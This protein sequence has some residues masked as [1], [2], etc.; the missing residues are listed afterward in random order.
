LRQASHFSAGGEAGAAT[1]AQ[2]GALD[3]VEH[4]RR[5]ADAADGRP[6]RQERMFDAIRPSLGVR[7]RAARSASPG[8]RS[9]PSRMSARR[10]LSSTLKILGRPFGQR[11]L[12]ADQFGDLVDACCGQPGNARSY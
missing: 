6:S 4:G 3:F 2:V 11:H 9:L 8:F 1:A 10:M 12:V 5:T 7:A